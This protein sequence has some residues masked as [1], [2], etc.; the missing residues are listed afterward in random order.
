MKDKKLLRAIDGVD[1]EFLDDAKPKEKKVNLTRIISIAVSLVLVIGISLWALIGG[2]LGQDEP[3][4]GV[5]PPVIDGGSG[6]DSIGEPTF[7]DLPSSSKSLAAVMQDYL[8][9]D[10]DDTVVLPEDGLDTDMDGGTENEVTNGSYFEVTDNQIEGIIEGDLYK[11]T[12]RYIFRYRDG[13]LY[14]YSID[15]ETSSEISALQIVDSRNADYADMFLSKD[16][17]TVTVIRQEYVTDGIDKIDRFDDLIYYYYGHYVTEIYSVDV[18]DV[19]NPVVR[20]TVEINGSSMATRKIGDKIYLITRV[21]F[22]KDD[23]DI[24]DDSTY[25]PGITEDGVIHTCAYERIYYCDEIKSASYYY[26]TVFNESDLSLASEYALLSEY[27]EFSQRVYFTK[28]HIL[29][30]HQ[31]G[32]KIS[33]EE[34]TSEAY[35]WIE[36]IDF[37]GNELRY[38]GCLEIRGWAESGQYSYDEQDGYLRV[39]ASTRTWKRYW[40]EKSSASLYVY[41]LSGMTLVASVDDFAPDGERATAVRFVGDKLYVCTAETA[42]YTDPVFFFDLSDY[43]NITQVNTGYIEGFSTSLI[44]I[45]GGYLLGIGRESARE[46]KI[47]IYKRDGDRVVSV[48]E[49]VFSGHYESDYH[50]YLIDREKGLF[51]FAVNYLYK[52][53]GVSYGH[54]YFLWRFDHDTESIGLVT[55]IS[56]TNEHTCFDRARAFVKDGY[57]YLTSTNDFTPFLVQRVDVD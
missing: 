6:G 26:V 30:E 38:R 9:S 54:G 39:V 22:V 36:L 25:I 44:D 1:E 43:S 11:A 5:I 40:I 28:C 45:G 42:K 10:Y 46:S 24:D 23:I 18:S 34:S 13:A 2:I 15:G 57:L 16:G 8:L 7:P 51:G 20:K 41:D 31:S 27:N 32:K 33:E 55:E 52:D 21:S 19:N 29:I 56:G 12:D 35:S 14:I 4:K 3:S 47:E 49:Y 53:Y 50:A 37:S 17:K 48:A